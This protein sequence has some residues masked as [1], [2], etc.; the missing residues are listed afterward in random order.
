MEKLYQEVNNDL[1]GL[2]YWIFTKNLGIKSACIN[3]DETQI[4][5]LMRLFSEAA[6]AFRSD[7][8]PMEVI[9]SFA[10]SCPRLPLYVYNRCMEDGVF[11]SQF[12]VLISKGKAI[13]PHHRRTHLCIC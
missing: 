11:K 4:E 6:R 13:P 3:F 9:K 7:G 8:V 2:S 12:L 1:W 5:S 10:N